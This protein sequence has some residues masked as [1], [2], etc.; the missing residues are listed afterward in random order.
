M[1]NNLRALTISPVGAGLP[2]ATAESIRKVL[3][4]GVF[5]SWS[6]AR[7][8]V[9]VAALEGRASMLAAGSRG[10]AVATV[11]IDGINAGGAASL[12]HYVREAP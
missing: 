7:E 10:N 1:T 4:T 12:C 3:V 2:P 6:V 5:G 9:L 8:L 11:L